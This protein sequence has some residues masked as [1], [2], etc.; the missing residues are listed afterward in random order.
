MRQ[1]LL[2]V[3][4]YRKSTWSGVGLDLALTSVELEQREE[5]VVNYDSHLE[6]KGLDRAVDESGCSSDS[7]VAVVGEDDNLD[8]DLGSSTV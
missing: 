1:V 4:V 3:V 6:D 7:V 5:H 2:G 8:D